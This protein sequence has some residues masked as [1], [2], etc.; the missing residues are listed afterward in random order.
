MP[1]APGRVLGGLCTGERTHGGH[2]LQGG[3]LEPRCLQDIYMHS[4]RRGRWAPPS[5]SSPLRWPLLT[6]SR[7]LCK[8]VHSLWASIYRQRPEEAS[9]GWWLSGEMQESRGGAGHT[10]P[11]RQRGVGPTVPR[12]LAW[13]PRQVTLPTQGGLAQASQP[14]P[15]DC[16]A[17]P[18]PAALDTTR[19]L[20]QPRRPAFQERHLFRPCGDRA[21]A[22]ARGGRSPQHPT[23][24]SS[25]AGS[26]SFGTGPAPAPS[27]HPLLGCCPSGAFRPHQDKPRTSVYCP[28]LHEQHAW[29]CSP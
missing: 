16:P 12:A 21:R 9:P 6:Q 8:S 29:L 10:C 13:R 4:P 23:R 22:L 25:H 14:L 3:S 5:G 24:F 7:R 1:R 2:G 15:A 19:R 11:E 18:L 28:G 26:L 17:Q 20:Q 27:N